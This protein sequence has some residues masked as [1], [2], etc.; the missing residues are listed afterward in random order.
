MHN[1]GNLILA[2]TRLTMMKTMMT[3]SKDQEHPQAR[4]SLMRK[5]VTRGANAKSHIL[6][7]WDTK[8]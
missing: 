2:L 5:S 3:I 4:L 8:P 6:G 1:E 7:A